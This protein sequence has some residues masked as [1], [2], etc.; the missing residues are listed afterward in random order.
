MLVHL[1]PCGFKSVSSLRSFLLLSS[2]VVTRLGVCMDVSGSCCQTFSQS[3]KCCYFLL[4]PVCA[5]QFR[6]DDVA[7]LV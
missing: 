6:S 4:S 3:C 2:C 1:Y 5:L 7:F